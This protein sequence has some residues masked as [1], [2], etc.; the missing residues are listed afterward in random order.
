M[1]HYLVID[2][3]TTGQNVIKHTLLAIGACVVSTRTC[4]VVE[5]RS[6]HIFR[7]CMP[8]PDPFSQATL[9][10]WDLNT[11]ND[12]WLNTAKGTGDGQTPL[13]LLYALAA[14]TNPWVCASEEDGMV[15]FVNWAKA[16]GAKFKKD[17]VVMMDTA[18]FDAGWM[19]AALGR[20]SDVT[21]VDS[22][23]YV[24]GSYA[25]P[26]DS[27]SFHMGVGLKLPEDGLWGGDRAA[28]S[29]FGIAGWPDWVKAVAH[30]H[31]PAHDAES[32]GLKAVFI[33]N[34][35]RAERLVNS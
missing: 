21:G 34:E 18:C 11:L 4:A 31:D 12:F 25:P 5:P 33:A 7:A 10:S 28:L 1:S 14:P 2:V 17:I 20:H 35:V 27:T 22:L 3:E 32:I 15:R 6:E 23:N 8:I 13:N 30:D 19:Q 9:K 26:R 16:M 29:R 24:L